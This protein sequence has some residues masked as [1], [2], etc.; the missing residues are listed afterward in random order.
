MRFDGRSS[1]GNRISG[2]SRAF[3]AA[4]SRYKQSSD[5]IVRAQRVVSTA[6]EKRDN[7]IQTPADLFD[8]HG[9]SLFDWAH[10]WARSHE[11][12][13]DCFQEAAIRIL[14]SWN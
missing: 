8:R 11:G 5:K 9:K 6:E 10:R 2:K 7:A 12:A 3:D 1:C 14:R 13:E 4:V